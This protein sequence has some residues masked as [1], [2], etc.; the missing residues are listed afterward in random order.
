MDT[1]EV[2]N[3]PRDTNLGR[4][5][6]ERFRIEETIGSG[7]M[8]IVYRA[9]DL[10]LA[11]PCA[12]KLL[13][14]GAARREAV[15]I[16]FCDE[17]RIV[18]QLYH[19]NIVE[20]IDFGEEPDGSLFLA[21]EFLRGQD[22]HALLQTEGELA[23]PRALDLIRQIGSALHCVHLAGIIHRDIKPRN[24][25]LTAGPGDGALRCVKVIDFGLSKILDAESRGS[26]GLL[27]G[28][29]E[30]LPP[31]AWSG[32]SGDVD[33]RAD[34]WALAV[35][36][37]R[38]LS[39]R[40]PFDAHE[41][42]VL[43]AHDIRTR[44][45]RPL[46]ELVPDL[47]SHIDAAIS[48]A[49]AKD[50]AQRFGTVSEFVRALHRLPLPA[51]LRGRPARPPAPTLTPGAEDSFCGEPTRV[52]RSPLEVPPSTQ[53]A[54]PLPAPPAVPPAPSV[55]ILPT[56]GAGGPPPPGDQL[57]WLTPQRI[58]P[59]R[60][61]TTALRLIPA[62]RDPRSVLQLGTWLSLAALTGLLGWYSHGAS[63]GASY[64]PAVLSA[65]HPAAIEPAPAPSDPEG[66]LLCRSPLGQEGTPPPR[67]VPPPRAQQGT[68]KTARGSEPRSKARGH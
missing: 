4:V 43:L 63:L 57:T 60:E 34:Q 29:P 10:A 22:L 35:L 47:P 56:L 11:Q 38:L 15:V 33:M 16:R 1:S 2:P 46:R 66:P 27:I 41:D 7:S 59:R 58:D 49:L 67:P 23:L 12:V 13:Q 6:K 36:A 3:T 28:T 5:L 54:L 30:Y 40:L 42:T 9:W 21:M 8:G 24:I 14:L 18:A 53:L 52:Q 55:E 62:R 44:P 61:P 37:Y 17:A 31:E 39:G 51:E 48:R 68:S 50:K 20:L 32:C 26:D 45:H 64:A 19:P 65:P 25:I